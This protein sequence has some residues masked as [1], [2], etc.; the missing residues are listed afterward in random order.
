MMSDRERVMEILGIEP[1]EIFICKRCARKFYLAFVEDEDEH[2]KRWRRELLQRK[3][4]NSDLS[5]ICGECHGTNVYYPGETF[6][7]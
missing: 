5:A 1:W 6:L 3:R 4:E 7:P 2:M